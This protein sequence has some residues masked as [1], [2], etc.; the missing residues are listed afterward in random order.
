MTQPFFKA[1]DRVVLLRDAYGETDDGDEV[2]LPVGHPGVVSAVRECGRP[3]GPQGP[4]LYD[5]DFDTPGGNVWLIY[6]AQD[7]ADLAP[8]RPAPVNLTAPEGA[9]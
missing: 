1:G 2:R 9:P 5:V 6:D 4:W 8:A 3:D 7:V